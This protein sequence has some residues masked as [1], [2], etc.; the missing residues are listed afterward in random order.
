VEMRSPLT[1][2]AAAAA[3]VESHDFYYK[4]PQVRLAEFASEAGT[5]ATLEGDV[6]CEVGDAIMTG[7]E[8]ERWPIRRSE[9]ERKYQPH[10][11]TRK[12]EAGEYIS[13]PAIV[14]AAQLRSARAVHL[15]HNKGVLNGQVGDWLVTYAPNNQSI[16]AQDIFTKTYRRVG[17]PVDIGISNA[18]AYA[19][20]KID[21]M[22]SQLRDLLVHTCFHVRVVDDD[23]LNEIS[24]KNSLWCLIQE[25]APDPNGPLSDP[26]TFSTDALVG[27]REGS[28]S[29]V[30]L[31]RDLQYR[32]A[33]RKMTYMRELLHKLTQAFIATDPHDAPKDEPELPAVKALAEQLFELY[34][35][36]AEL[37]DF[38]LGNTHPD[39]GSYMPSLA[40]GEPDGDDR[41][42][43][44]AG[45]IADRIANN[46]QRRWQRAVFGLTKDLAYKKGPFS[47]FLGAPLGLIQL[48]LFGALLLAC[49]TEF[50]DG[51]EAID[52][53]SSLQCDS[54]IWK[55]WVGP[56]SLVMYV[57]ILSFGWL[58]YIILKT[59]K[60][61]NKHQDYR[62]LAEYMRVQYVWAALRIAEHVTEAEP[63]TV[64][65]ESGWVVSA[66]RALRHH[67]VAPGNAE[68]PPSD[69]RR[70]W[71]KEA[72]LLEQRDYYD[73]ILIKRREKAI[74]R[75]RRY[76]RI[77]AVIAIM[78]FI[79]LFMLKIEAPF[80][81]LFRNFDMGTHF[82]IVIMLLSLAIWAA[83]HKVIELYAWENE[84]QRGQVVLSAL[85]K[86]IKELDHREK[87]VRLIFIECGRFFA[88][89]QAAWHAL[90]RAKPIEAPGG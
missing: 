57:G 71:A 12:G 60:M 30:G 31:V 72:F 14:T 55:T 59:E 35:F 64:P 45:A 10:G 3:E 36:N 40:G 21:A 73:N 15:P 51:C 34:Q 33:H 52:R 46:C 8:G 25:D 81:D 89:D 65:S 56:V 41:T 47:L 20:P 66:V 62:L 84:A 77:A 32:A 24:K 54:H 44:E 23:R 37:R 4:V 61:E 70:Q 88:M 76:G 79:A 19:K 83:L 29:L 39:K 68:N 90:R 80:I 13:H 58:K 7:G 18:A 38:Y 5:I 49:F 82:F 86:A 28:H 53:W 67:T 42:F 43:W 26:L 87:P 50:H 11:Q 48:G 17:V 9:F 16:V 78:A 63:P 2:D 85:R 75:V 1:P 74:R 6:P 69:A 22:V 27:A